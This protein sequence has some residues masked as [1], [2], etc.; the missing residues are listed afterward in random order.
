MKQKV[1]NR[2][3]GSRAEFETQVLHEIMDELERRSGI[4]GMDIR[5]F[6]GLERYGNVQKMEDT[7]ISWESGNMKEEDTF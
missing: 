3:M 2:N 4:Q 7:R 6:S 1:E 5:G